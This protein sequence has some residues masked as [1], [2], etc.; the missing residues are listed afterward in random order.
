[1]AR[2]TVLAR[3]EPVRP[4]TLVV[5]S[6]FGTGA[7]VMVFL[8]LMAVYVQRRAAALDAGREWYPEGVIELGPAGIMM[9]TLVFSSFTAQWAVQAVKNDDRP[10][11]Y[12]ALGLTALFGAAVLNQFW[13]VYQDT[14][15]TI[16]GSEAQ[17]LFYVITGTF[18]VMLIAAMVFVAVTTLKALA[19]QFTRHNADAVVAAVVYWQAVVLMYGIVWYVIFITK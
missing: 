10:H 7:A 11:G 14:A 1:M 6:L 8:G 13:F 2:T 17:L 12:V 19:G 18:L 16:D 5:A 15:F 3:P 9:T 4:R